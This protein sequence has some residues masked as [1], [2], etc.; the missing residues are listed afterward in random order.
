MAA[1]VPAN[2]VIYQYEYINVPGVRANAFQ[3]NVF[4]TPTPLIEPPR[5]P[6]ANGGGG[7]GRASGVAPRGDVKVP[8]HPESMTSIPRIVNPSIHVQLRRT[9][10]ENSG[11][12]A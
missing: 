12:S 10:D 1:W 9:G 2:V 3:C 8:P 5:R 4:R 11:P 6:A 7:A